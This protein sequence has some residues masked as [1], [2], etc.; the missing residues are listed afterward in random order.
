MYP[1]GMAGKRRVLLFLVPLL[2]TA[3]V[4]LLDLEG[5]LSRPSGWIYD[6]AFRL[7]PPAAAVREILLLDVDD[8]AVAVAGPWP[9]TAE[10]I[11]NGL[12]QLQEFDAD[13]VVFDLALPDTAEQASTGVAPSVVE[14]FDREFAAIT[15]NIGTL[16]EGIRRGSV[17]PKDAPGFVDALIG[18][19]ETAKARL[20]GE[21]AGG[22]S[23]PDAA[24][25]GA[26]RAFGRAW[27]S[28]ELRS[29]RS[30]EAVPAALYASARGDGFRGADADPDGVL[31]RAL[32]VVERQGR[33]LVPA[34][35]EALLDRLG[36]PSLRLEGRRLVLAGARPPGMPAR[37]V[38][39]DLAEDG[40]LLLDW[41][42]TATGSTTEDGFRHLSWGDLAELDWLEKDLVAALRAIR[43]S[44]ILG[45][46]GTSLLDRYDDA[47]ALRER[48]L[49]GDGTASA[50]EWLDARNR[51][52]ALAEEALLAPAADA[53]GGPADE[54]PPLLAEAR[55]A[56][57]D[58]RRS[59]AA[60]RE[61]LA[62]SFCIVSLATRSAPGSLGRTPRGA[63]ASVGSSSAALVNTVL[64]ARRLAETPDWIGKALG[65]ALS[66]LATIAALR[67]RVR[68]TLLA[69]VLLMAATVAGSGGLLVAAGWYLDPVVAAASTGLT[70]A[71]LAGVKALG[72][73]PGRRALRRRFANR[74]PRSILRGL[75]AEPARAPAAG[76]EQRVTV[77]CGRVA[78]LSAAAGRGNPAAL[79]AMLNGLHAELGRIV[80]A[81]GGTIGRAEGDALEAY[82]GAPL[83]GADDSRR[84]CRCALRMQAAAKEL[85]A[86]F[87]ADHIIPAPLALRIGIA[88]GDC[89]AGDLGMPGV[90]GYTVLGAARDAAWDLARSCERFGAA[91]LVTGPVWE[92]GG[93]ELLARMLD[94]LPLP[95]DPDPV[96][97]LELVSELEGADA[98]TVEAIGLFNEGLALLEAGNRSGAAA[99]FERVH[100]RLP[101]DGPSAV[102]AAR[103]RDGS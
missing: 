92:A 53:D 89:L 15:G 21:I 26:M 69:G 31:R 59:R 47:A 57:A 103:C 70:C 79:A 50:A 25:A 40:R 44:G 32:P 43:E 95:T 65:V 82:F 58:I 14:A 67:L 41:P 91:T 24:L 61:Q 64:T 88:A 34:A 13:R 54:A 52:F 46:R 7:K 23:D 36:S 55:R 93:K 20:L 86:R 2:A 16:F 56:L 38:V 4:L 45:S 18:L 83:E 74:I 68:G 97:C 35:F 51:F 9:W 96:R 10:T 66:L 19:V 33:R 75:V 77:L 60:L 80:L 63:V 99:L 30:A 84:A 8:R 85:G 22:R 5:W 6:A 42:A 12:A 27:I 71:A 28:W 94:R 37:D 48:L 98:A 100:D 3:L 62:Q 76:S 90:P 29:D 87:I 72:R 101:N 73:F 39:L 1:P 49:A 81:Y 102:Y 11:A 17:L 78:G